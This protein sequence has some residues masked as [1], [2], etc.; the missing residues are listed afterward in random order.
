MDILKKNSLSKPTVLLNL[1]SR[2]NSILN[3]IKSKHIASNTNLNML[4]VIKNKHKSIKNIAI[5]SK[6]NQKVNST[7]INRPKE[8]INK[9]ILP[10]KLSR[11][12][13]YRKIDQCSNNTNLLSSNKNINKEKILSKYNEEENK[14]DLAM[15]N[16]N[17]TNNITNNITNI[18]INNDVKN[19]NKKNDKNNKNLSDKNSSNKVK[20]NNLTCS[21]SIKRIHL[22]KEIL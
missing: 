3:K 13:S 14:Q 19:R 6:V 4:N 22:P 1:G 9:D 17:V 20:K 7:S 15:N 16:N 10:N 8:L 18:F 11:V 21:V 12:F 5:Q 2:N